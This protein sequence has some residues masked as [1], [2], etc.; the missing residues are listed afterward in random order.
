[1]IN[2]NNFKLRFDLFNKRALVILPKEDLSVFFAGNLKSFDT[3]VVAVAVEWEGEME[4][5][6]V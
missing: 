4:F 2:S 6:I 5:T 1:M 3:E